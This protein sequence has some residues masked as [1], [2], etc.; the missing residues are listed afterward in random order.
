[1]FDHATMLNWL[2]WL[3]GYGCCCYVCSY[4]LQDLW[5]ISWG[6][7]IFVLNIKNFKLKKFIFK[8]V[9]YVMCEILSSA[10]DFW[11]TKP[12]KC[13]SEGRTQNNKLCNNDRNELFLAKVRHGK[14]FSTYPSQ[15]EDWVLVEK[16]MLK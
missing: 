6:I 12:W 15:W 9:F 7:K 3:T 8:F 5:A 16:T 14:T 2:M 10:I 11:S 4:S 1:M 13:D